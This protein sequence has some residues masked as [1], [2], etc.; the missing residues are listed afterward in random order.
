MK[1]KFFCQ[2]VRFF[3]RNSQIETDVRNFQILGEAFMKKNSIQKAVSILIL[4]AL[5]FSLSVSVLANAGM[6][7]ET[8]GTTGYYFDDTWIRSGNIDQSWFTDGVVLPDGSLI[9]VGARTDNDGMRDRRTMY[10]QKI[11]PTGFRD[12]S[13]GGGTGTFRLLAF[14]S[15]SDSVARAVRFQ[16]DGKIVV[17]GVC[18]IFANP[19]TPQERQSGFGMCA[20][21]LTPSGDLD[22]S[23]GGNTVQ[24]QHT[25]TDTSTFFNYTMPQ[26]TTFLHY[27]G[28]VESGYTGAGVV[29]NAAAMDMALHADGRITLAGYS[30]TRDFNAQNQFQ[31]YNRFATIATLTPSGALSSAVNIA[32]DQTFAA[33]RRSSRAFRGVEAKS[34]GGVIAV[35]YTP[36]INET[37]GGTDGSRWIV[38]DSSTANT[39]YS[40]DG[41]TGSKALGVRFTRGNQ[42]LVSGSYTTSGTSFI[43]TLLMRFNSNLTPDTTFGT[44]GRRYY[45]HS[46]SDT[47]NRIS[48]FSALK[49]TEVQPDGRILGIGFSDLRELPLDSGPGGETIFRF[50]PNGAVDR[51]L[52]DG[53]GGSP[54]DIFSYGYQGLF[55]YVNGNIA[56]RVNAVGF[57]RTQPDGKILAG[58]AYAPSDAVRAG[59]T[60]RKSTLRNQFYPDFDNDGG[61]DISVYRPSTGVWHNLNSFNLSYTP[62]Q[63]GISTDKLAPADYDG[64]GKTDRAVFRDGTWYILRSSDIQVA[65]AQWG[66]ASDLPRPG[67]FNGDGFAD[68]AV[69]RPSSG[70]WYI[71]YSNPIQPGNVTTAIVQFGQA[72]DVPLIADFD[73]DGKS[74]IAVFRAG[75]W[76]FIRSST[77]SAGNIQFGT[78][79]DIPVMG[80]Y[81]GDSKSDLAVF[82]G[83]TWYVQKSSD[84]TYIILNWGVAG[85]KPVPGDFDKDGKNDF[86]IY[87]DGTWWIL[88]SG[89]GGYSA[90]NFGLASD[91]PIQSAYLQ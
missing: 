47:S 33:A 59:V 85:D 57:A 54:T 41:V 31:G 70:V 83:G 91:I 21:R 78:S 76:H 52:G 17:A 71:L 34:D 89:D 48:I 65:Y 12:P 27:P 58:G 87:R 5:V 3:S 1:K 84:G 16:P 30:V 42:I 38:Y 4:A 72:G 8:Y 49:L 36:I 46:V 18:N 61:S 14:A 19:F 20:I 11:L 62:V 24:V 9:A 63:W 67:D 90:V 13:F 86:A 22:T 7:D 51:S 50:N 73:G 64:D 80:D 23:F 44:G 10:V 40:E 29:V 15:G 28:Q 77:G 66:S 2:N 32:G 53:F 81:D 82:R 60:R 39:Y 88:R 68:L 74:D 79:G 45:W 43:G 6:V 55:R 75:I 69:F 56:Q 25:P 35:G 37:T 26:G